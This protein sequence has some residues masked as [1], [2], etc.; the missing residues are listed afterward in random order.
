MFSQTVKSNPHRTC[1]IYEDRRWSFLDLEEYSNRV[2]HYFLRM[3]YK[4]GD[5]VAL[6][7]DNRL[8]S[9]GDNTF[10][11]LDSH[12]MFAWRTQLPLTGLCSLSKQMNP[13][14]QLG[15]TRFRLCHSPTLIDAFPPSIIFLLHRPEYIGL[16]LGLAKIGVVP[17]LINNNLSGQPLLHSIN[18]ASATA[19]IYGS[20]LSQSKYTEQIMARP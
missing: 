18:S 20:E 11:S 10:A 3:G 15:K 13:A 9:V 17:A 14:K 4:P 16:W 19:C 8:V 12:H 5:C 1:L 6:F 2:A 7:M